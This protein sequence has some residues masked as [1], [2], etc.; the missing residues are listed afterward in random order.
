MIQIGNT[1]IMLQ[2]PSGQIDQ[3]IEK[4]HTL[5]L[6]RAFSKSAAVNI[7]RGSNLLF[8]NYPALPAPR[9]NQIVLPTGATR[10]GYGL[11]LVTTSQ[12]DAILAESALTTRKGKLKVT[13]SS[14]DSWKTAPA[15]NAATFQTHLSLTMS[16]LPPRPMTPTGLPA[17]AG[18]ED[19]WVLPMVDQRYWWQYLNVDLIESESFSTIQGIVDFLNTKLNNTATLFYSCP[20][21]KH[22][23]VPDIAA[24]NNYENVAV[25]IETLAW[26]IG[27]QVVPEI[28]TNSVRGTAQDTGFALISV[29]D[30]PV[31]HDNNLRGRIGL[32]P[33]TRP[34][35][36][37]VTSP[38]SG[39]E[40]VGFPAV[41]MGGPVTIVQGSA[42]L[43]ETLFLPA[44][45]TY[46]KRKPSEVGLSTVRTVAG[47]SGV[48]RVKF[49][50]AD[51][52]PDELRDQVVRDFYNRFA[53]I[54]DYTFSGIQKWQL[55]AFDDCAVFTQARFTGSNEVRFQTRVRSWMSNLMPET[56]VSASKTTPPTTGT[57]NTGSGSCG[58]CLNCIDPDA[59]NSHSECTNLASASVNS[60]FLFK[61]VSDCCDNTYDSNIEL[62]H[63]DGTCTWQ[64]IEY[65]C[66]EKFIEEP[67]LNPANPE[68]VENIFFRWILTVGATWT[69][70][71]QRFYRK[72]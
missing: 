63:V 10:W 41:A 51:P 48:F 45:G 12:K 7:P 27:C 24:G 11:F 59:E 13:F 19:L 31:I 55:T 65:A 30:S 60:W 6:M 9:L 37:A 40:T 42:F 32:A 34:S 52:V 46:A 39:F 35:S 66:K 61:D 20:N 3:H 33:C 57:G 16:P 71:E 28:N 38:Q 8:P 50:D 29:D 18:V 44:A 54:H 53:R 17:I 49:K 15:T 1:P 5:D 4:H 68:I 23:K 43:P 67:F 14:G 36:G 58:N 21:T 25:V 47:T 2:D 64:S 70:L 69:E 62:V 72:T 22:N 56:M 26:H